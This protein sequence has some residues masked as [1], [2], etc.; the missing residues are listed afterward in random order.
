MVGVVSY[1]YY[2][3]SFRIKIANIA[4]MWGK[5]ATDVSSSLQVKEK[6]VSSQD[7]D[8]LTMAYESSCQALHGISI[9][10]KKI[11]AVFFGT[12]SP[13]YAVNPSST[14]LAE[15]LGIE[16]HYLAS[17][18]QF[19]CKAATGAIIASTGLITSK[20]TSYVLVVASDK[21]TAKPHDALEYTT[22][23][24]SVSLL[25][26]KKNPLL[27]IVDMESFSSDTPDFWRREGIR[28]P[29][30][31]GRFTGKPSYFHHIMNSSQ[32]ILKRNKIKPSQFAHAVFH[33]P[34]GKFPRQVAALLGFT[35]DQIKTSLTI[36]SLGN[37]Y[38]ASSLMGLVAILEIAKPG[39]Y[40]FLASYGSGAG[41]DAFIFRVTKEILNRRQVFQKKLS[42]KKYIDYQTYLRYM[43]II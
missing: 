2:I 39:E 30:H 15:F 13:P 21:A 24:G 12:E 16:G 3:P 40:I 29:S 35:F 7:E 33:M 11:G 28:Y 18:M 43:N 42:E 27:E 14:I 41:S 32:T 6:A 1:G 17:D 38:T 25:L 34:N 31:G 22:S 36:E 26:G 9:D 20:H 10:R 19:A 8:A 37:S 23:S 4:G 5:N